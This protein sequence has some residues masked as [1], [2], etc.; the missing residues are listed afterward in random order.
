MCM[1]GLLIIKCEIGL[2]DKLR[3]SYCL[4]V[5]H[6][7]HDTIDADGIYLVVMTCRKGGSNACNT[8][9]S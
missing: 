7:L 4:I 6:N 3:C 9:Y 5:V 2:P 1:R 8:S